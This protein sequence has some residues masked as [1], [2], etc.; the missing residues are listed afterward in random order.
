MLVTTLLF[1]GCA[2]QP[3]PTAQSRPEKLGPGDVTAPPSLRALPELG[4]ARS[5]QLQRALSLAGQVFAAPLPPPPVE[6][7]YDALSAWVENDVAHWIAQRRDAV[8]ETRFQFNSS[9]PEPA[10]R[11]IVCAVIG[12]LHEDTAYQLALIPQP[13]ELDN[14]PEIAAMFHELVHGQAEPF[15]NA[16][17]TEYRQCKAAGEELG[18]AS[19]RF[20]H[21]CQQRRDR[22]L[23]VEANQAEALAAKP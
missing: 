15:E 10:T 3:A 11:V 23:R 9:D 6:R 2:T 1:L 12:L 17:L 20:A 19:M 7:K 16:A 14:E 13:Q 4:E 5:S 8:E 18:G 21:F 22:L